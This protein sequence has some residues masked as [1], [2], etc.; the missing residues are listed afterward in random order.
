MFESEANSVR[1]SH[2]A[3]VDLFPDGAD[4]H[5]QATCRKGDRRRDSDD[6]DFA[7]VYV[8]G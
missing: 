5:E 3:I 1:E 7:F 2:P 4:F 8:D 6:R